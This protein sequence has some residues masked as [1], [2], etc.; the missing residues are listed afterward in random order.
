MLLELNVV[1]NRSPVDRCRQT[2][3]SFHLPQ[4]FSV[5]GFDVGHEAVAAVAPFYIVTTGSAH[6]ASK[7]GIL[8]QLSDPAGNRVGV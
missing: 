7:S 3:A 2:R 1:A 4:Q 5:E 8:K 6:L